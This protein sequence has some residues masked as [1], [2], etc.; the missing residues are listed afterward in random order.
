MTYKVNGVEITLQP[1]TGRWLGRAVL[2]VT[3]L[4]HPVYPSLRSYELVWGAMTPAEFNQLQTFFNAVITTGSA[5]VDLPQYGAST[6]TFYSY[7]GC[8]L[9]EPEASVYFTEHQMDVTLIINKVQT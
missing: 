5:V 7:S 1:T 6:Y 8:A 9:Q 3:G 2:G 4:A